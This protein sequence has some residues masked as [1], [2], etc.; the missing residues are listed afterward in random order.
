MVD[1]VNNGIFT[2]RSKDKIDMFVPQ[3]EK[4]LYF[5]EVYVV[6]F[7]ITNLYYHLVCCGF[8]HWHS[9]RIMFP[10]QSSRHSDSLLVHLY[11][12]NYF[13]VLCSFPLFLQ[14]LALPKQQS[15]LEGLHLLMNQTPEFQQLHRVMSLETQYGSEEK[16]QRELSCDK[17]LNIVTIQYNILYLT[18][19]T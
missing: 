15:L 2:L 12:L 10:F 7:I 17:V 13:R 9:P 18:K 5:I 3:W 4:S 14:S 6:G 19:V 8:V 1:N 16:R 11:F